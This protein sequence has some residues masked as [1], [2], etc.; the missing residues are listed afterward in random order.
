M[1]N[2][3]LNTQQKLKIVEEAIEK[4]AY[5]SLTFHPNSNTKVSTEEAIDTFRDL[6]S[7][8]IIYENSR[9]SNFKKYSDERFEGTVHMPDDFIPPG[10]WA[11][12]DE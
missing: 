8:N 6:D 11:Y 9:W 7:R 2:K 12:D 1:T 4:G 3:P 10:G 5:V